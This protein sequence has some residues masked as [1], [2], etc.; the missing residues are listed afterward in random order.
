MLMN[1]RSTHSY[2]RQVDGNIQVVVQ[3]VGVLLR[4]QK[5]QEC[6]GWISLVTTT[7]L[8]H[9][10]GTSLRQPFLRVLH[11]DSLLYTDLYTGMA[12]TSS[13][14]FSVL[15]GPLHRHEPNFPSFIHPLS[16][17]THN[18][19]FFDNSNLIRDRSSSFRNDGI[20]LNKVPQ[21]MLVSQS[22]PSS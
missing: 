19:G 21:G 3:E 12:A 1:T 16:A 22:R 13:I 6:G 20:P 8:I 15:L 14:T 2:L 4:V 10:V 5:F 18:V 7:H 11:Q 9:L 17:R